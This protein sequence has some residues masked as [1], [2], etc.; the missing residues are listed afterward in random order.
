LLRI[1]GIL[2]LVIVIYFLK[3]NFIEYN[4][5]KSISSCIVVQKRTSESFDLEKSKKYCEEEIRKQKGD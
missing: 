2:F 5:Q 4:L 3:N 1:V